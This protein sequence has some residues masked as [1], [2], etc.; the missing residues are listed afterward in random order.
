M[1]HLYIE[2]L[3]IYLYIENLDYRCKCKWSENQVKNW[4]FNPMFATTFATI[5]SMRISL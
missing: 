1:T 5:S 3:Y 4:N 2:I